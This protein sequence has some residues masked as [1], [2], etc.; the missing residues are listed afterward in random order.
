MRPGQ[1]FED[2]EV[3]KYYRYRPEY[4]AE[5]FERLSSISSDNRSALD[6]GCGTGKIARNLSGSFRSVTAVDA[7]AAMLEIAGSLPGGNASNINWQEGL[8][9]SAEL[10]GAP[11]DLI[12]AAASIHWM[13]QEVLFPRLLSLANP[14]HIFAVVEGDGA[15]D[16]PWQ[17]DWDDFL[18]YWIFKL[19]GEKY[20]PENPDSAHTRF[21]T[22]YRDWIDLEGTEICVST[23]FQQ[24]ISDFTKC[25]HS[26]DTFTTSKLGKEIDNFDAS[27]REVLLPYSDGDSVIYKV[28]T[29]LE[30]GSIKI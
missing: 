12:V 21:M 6:L 3:A 29:R 2:L 5:I 8:A 26:R 4:P 19:K 30:Y 7:S 13:S 14:K 28:R 23:P 9:E 10:P 24:K 11:F 27:L 15:F 25:Q 1:S 16:P 22:R 18:E 17:S 20:E